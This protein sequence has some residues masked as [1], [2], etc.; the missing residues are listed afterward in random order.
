MGDYLYLVL[1]GYDGNHRPVYI[2]SSPVSLISDPPAHEIVTLPAELT[3]IGSEA[4]AVIA[5]KGVVIPASVLY[6]ADDAFANSS[7]PTLYGTS[8]YARTYASEHGFV[9]RTPDC[10]SLYGDGSCMLQQHATF[11]SSTPAANVK[12]S[13]SLR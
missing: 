5:A 8:D 4:F 11:P 10:S 3:E 9:F 13:L 1:S 6:I 7:I 2:E 12:T